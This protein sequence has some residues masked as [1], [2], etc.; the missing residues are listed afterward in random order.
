MI[1]HKHLDVGPSVWRPYNFCIQ[2]LY[3]RVALNSCIKADDW[4]TSW[5][6]N[7]SVRLLVNMLVKRHSCCATRAH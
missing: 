3:Q 2:F 6:I 4:K 1:F 7:H 5:N